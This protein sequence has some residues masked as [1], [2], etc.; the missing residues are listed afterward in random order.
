M[1]IFDA[2]ANLFKS[3]ERR[4]RENE[5]AVRMAIASLNRWDRTLEKKKDTIY[6]LAKEAR[7]RAEDRQYQL[8]MRGVQMI[9][10]GQSRARAMR[11]SLEMYSTM[12]DMQNMSADFARLMGRL[13]ADIVN[14]LKRADFMRNIEDIQ[15]GIQSVE[16]TMSQLEFMLESVDES[17]AT[18][19]GSAIADGEEALGRLMD[20]QADQERA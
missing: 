1:S 2:V 11:L 17:F 12:Y 5:A 7:S 10:Q 20:A 3:P 8:A 18:M 16:D 14:A 19:N 4:R 6:R 9:L 13:G 15:T